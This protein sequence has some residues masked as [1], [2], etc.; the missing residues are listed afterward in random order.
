VI[1]SATAGQSH[2]SGGVTIAS[3]TG[4]T[5]SG[6]G[7]TAGVSGNA[8]LQTGDGG[9]ATASTGGI[10]GASGTLTLSTGAGGA[11]TGGSGTRTGGNSG[12]I[13]IATGAGGTGAS[14]NGTP[15]DIL[16]KGGASQWLQVVGATGSVVVGNAAVATNA[17][18]GFLYIPTCAGTPT[19][20]PT[21]FTGRVA[22]VYDT[23]NHQFWIYDGGWKQP[24]TPAGAAIVTWQ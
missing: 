6:A 8:S 5:N 13:T 21:G 10:G 16:F 4:G 1:N 7:N 3:N 20:T 11:A 17:S 19:G 9:A 18:D 12:A 14:A 15:G 23:T 24:K 22:L 2:V